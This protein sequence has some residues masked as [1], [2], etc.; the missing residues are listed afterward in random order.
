[1]VGIVTI[2]DAR[3][4]TSTAVVIDAVATH[5]FGA[6]IH[7]SV[8]VIA[9]PAPL[10]GQTTTLRVSKPVAVRVRAYTAV[11]VYDGPPVG[12]S[13]AGVRGGNGGHSIG[14]SGPACA[15]RIDRAPGSV[16]CPSC[17]GLATR[18]NVTAPSRG[19]ADIGHATRAAVVVIIIASAARPRRYTPVGRKNDSQCEDERP[20][21]FDSPVGV[22]A[23]AADPNLR[24][25]I[26]Y[27]QDLPWSKP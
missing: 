2:L 8:A 19:S 17:A 3:E 23:L 14:G 9:I 21:H 27:W 5:L 22:D 25:V 20:L 26:G 1:M 13:G 11:R 12:V 24:A 10:L 6:G 7:L 15:R 18:R 16:R 4:V